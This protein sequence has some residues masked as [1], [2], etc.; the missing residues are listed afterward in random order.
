MIYIEMSSNMGSNDICRNLRPKG[1]SG[2]D[3]LSL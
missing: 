1:Y 2:D 3:V